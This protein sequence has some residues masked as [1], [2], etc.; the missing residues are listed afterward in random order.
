MVEWRREWL[1]SDD[2]LTTRPFISRSRARVGLNVGWSTFATFSTRA[3]GLQ[4]NGALMSVAIQGG[5]EAYLWAALWQIAMGGLQAGA[6][7][8]DPRGAEHDFASQMQKA[9]S[10]MGSAVS[11]GAWSLGGLGRGSLRAV[12]WGGVHGAK[13]RGQCG[14]NPRAASHAQRAGRHSDSSLSD[15]AIFC[16]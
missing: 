16:V 1:V 14:H 9:V 6:L 2:A 4:H 13:L 7:P 10:F 5:F 12:G 11:W 3:C 15:N 8:L